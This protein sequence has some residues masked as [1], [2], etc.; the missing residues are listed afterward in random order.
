MA[1]TPQLNEESPEVRADAL[2]ACGEISQA[3]LL[4]HQ[5]LQQHPH[6]LD[7]RVRLGRLALLQNSPQEAITHLAAVLNNGLHARANWEALANAYLANGETASAALCFERV[8]RTELAGTL[9]VLADRTL[10]R[11]DTCAGGSELLWLTEIPLPVIQAEI[12]NV[13]VNLLLDTAAGDLILDE[14]VAVA[15]KIP[16]GGSEERYFA[17][18]QL[19]TVTYGHLERLQLG[20]FVFHDLLTQIM[21][22]QSKFATYAPLVPIHGIVGLSVLSHVH[23][24]LDFKQRSLKLSSTAEFAEPTNTG[25][26]RRYPFWIADS[27]FILVGAQT[28]DTT[29]SM[30][31]L[32]TGMSGAEVAISAASARMTAAIPVANRPDAGVGGGGAVSGTRV[33]VPKVKVAGRE[34]HNLNGLLL[35]HFPLQQRFGFNTVGLLGCDFF[36]ATVLSL[37]FV[38]MR[39]SLRGTS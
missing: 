1:V 32:D 34:R 6:R 31:V 18:G 11:V 17:G 38:T 28:A 25:E 21:P 35:D 5:V 19:A 29:A 2:L 4:Y 37:D 15:A 20:A 3:A 7:L 12:N 13:T 36:E 9:A 39:L 10:C 26:V 23:S 30:W 27:Q 24:V 22:L 16:H 8:G 33:L 14:S